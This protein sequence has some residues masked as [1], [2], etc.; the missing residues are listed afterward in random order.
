VESLAKEFFGVTR[1]AS[2]LPSDFVKR[3][4]QRIGYKLPENIELS[5]LNEQ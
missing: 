2:E 3:L 4:A 5:K 1:D